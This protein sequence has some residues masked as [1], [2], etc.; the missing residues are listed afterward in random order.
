MESPWSAGRSVV[1]ISADHASGLPSLPD[2]KGFAEAI[3]TRAD[4][5]VVTGQR[6]AAFR[7]LS[8]YSMGYLP[9]WV[10]FLWFIAGHWIV[11]M[12]VLLLT[13]MG[14]A[15]MTRRRLRNVAYKRLALEGRT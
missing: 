15:W 12:P 8:D 13:A 9:P 2:L 5:L 3:Q 6:R 10:E 7:V 4:V 14:F 11:L 1:I